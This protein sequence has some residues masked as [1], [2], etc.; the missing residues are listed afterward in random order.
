MAVNGKVLVDDARRNLF[1]FSFNFIHGDG[2]THDI[3]RIETS[4][5]ERRKKKKITANHDPDR[6]TIDCNRQSWRV[7]D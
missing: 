1:F 3:H 6:F 2:P 7:K 4:R 5:Q